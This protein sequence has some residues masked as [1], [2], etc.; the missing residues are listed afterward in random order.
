MAKLHCFWLTRRFHFLQVFVGANIH[1]IMHM[2]PNTKPDQ[3]CEYIH[4][5]EHEEYEQQRDLS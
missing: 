1:L 5:Y 2:L 3:I 4:H